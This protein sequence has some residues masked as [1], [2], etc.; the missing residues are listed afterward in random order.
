LLTNGIV[1][2]MHEMFANHKG[3]YEEPMGK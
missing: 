3:I 1:S 2:Q